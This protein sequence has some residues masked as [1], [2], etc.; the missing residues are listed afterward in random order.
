MQVIMIS[1]VV[2]RAFLKTRLK[3]NFLEF[4]L[5]VNFFFLNMIFFFS[6]FHN[7][8]KKIKNSKFKLQ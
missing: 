4:K 3:I 7:V 5:R 6:F 8:R 2:S 1:I